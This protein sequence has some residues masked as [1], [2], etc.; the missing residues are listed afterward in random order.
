MPPPWPG[1][2]NRGNT[3]TKS[4]W[5]D[6]RGRSA[7]HG[8]ARDRL[9][10]GR[11]E[12]RLPGP[13]RTS[14][15]SKS[16]SQAVLGEGPPRSGRER[17]AAAED[18]P[19]VEIG[20][21]TLAYLS[22]TSGTTGTPKAVMGRH[23]SL[24]HFTPWLAET[25]GLTADDRFSMLSGLAHDPLHR[26]VF[27]P[28]Q[29][30]AAVVAPEPEEV[31]APGYLARWLREAAVTVAHLTPAMGQLIA[32]VPGGV[33]A[34]E[35]VPSLRRAFFVGDVLT[36]GDVERLRRLAPN[37]GVINYYGSTETQRAVAYHVVEADDGRVKAQ[38]TA[39][40]TADH[41]EPIPASHER[42]EPVPPRQ[43]GGGTGAQR[44]GEGPIRRRPP[45]GSAA[46]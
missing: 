5:A 13:A 23:G 21:D 2:R 43:F 12:G 1:G 19:A 32:D 4:A 18:A 24:T 42:S 14:E 38:T 22:F 39:R 25:F 36:R 35:P 44:Q 7:L 17:A 11:G 10:L 45:P 28:L 34:A 16:L 37:L 8:R 31:G 26:D 3:H 9:R 46:P 41:T 40:V 30:G 33:E 20:P 6:C 29:L 15:A 27:T